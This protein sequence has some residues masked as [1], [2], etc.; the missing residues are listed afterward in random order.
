[1]LPWFCQLAGALAYLREL[2]LVHTDIK[3]DNILL[4]KDCQVKLCDFG[5]AR[6]VPTA[7]KNNNQIQTKICENLENPE[8]ST[9]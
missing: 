2:E 8:D 7:V 1:M 9:S 4:N 5:F 6:T 3:P